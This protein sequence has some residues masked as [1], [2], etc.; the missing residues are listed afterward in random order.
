[1]RSRNRLPKARF[2]CAAVLTTLLRPRT[3]LGDKEARKEGKA[4]ASGFA[5][6]DDL[7]ADVLQW[8]ITSNPEAAA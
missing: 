3:Y 8:L 7:N 2:V 6:S 4:V 1:M 5:G